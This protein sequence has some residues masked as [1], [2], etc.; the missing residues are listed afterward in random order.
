[1]KRF[2]LSAISIILSCFCV[3]S[4]Q[5]SAPKLVFQSWNE[6]QLIVPL[7]RG[8]DAKGKSFDRVTAT[9]SGIARIGRKD[10]D[11]LDDR[12]GLTFDFRVSR[13]ISLFAGGLYRRDENVRNVIRYEKRLTAG[14]TFSTVCH[15]FTFKD[16]NQFEHRFRN[17]R[18]DVNLY[19]QRIR[20][21]R[22]LKFREK[23]IFSPFI[24]EEGFYNITDGLWVQ[25]EFYA[26]ITRK[27][28]PRTALD[29]AYLNSSTKSV[30]T[31]GINLVLKIKLR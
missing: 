16:R 3:V 15:K 27:L 23:E 29:I 25:N 30:H 14:A 5:N 22:S 10:F 28:S 19:R 17:S 12:A 21:S 18:A 2:V 4:A 26:G 31:N 9:F 6:I 1:M 11:F 24:S 8:K 7:S 20:I 13:H